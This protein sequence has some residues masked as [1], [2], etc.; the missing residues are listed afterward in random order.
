MFRTGLALA[1]AGFGLM[2]MVNGVAAHGP[3][4]PDRANPR[5]SVAI[6]LTDGCREFEGADFGACVSEAARAGGEETP[7]AAE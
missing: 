2:T 3:D 4:L 5:A 1:I 6:T 7:D